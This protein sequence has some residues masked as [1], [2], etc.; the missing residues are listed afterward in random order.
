LPALSRENPT[1]VHAVAE[2][3]DTPVRTL[4]VALLS[5]ELC[6]VHVEPFQTSASGASPPALCA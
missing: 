2:V 6:A 4:N 5:G 3:H 1:A